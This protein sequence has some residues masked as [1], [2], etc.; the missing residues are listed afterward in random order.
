MIHIQKLVKFKLLDRVPGGYKVHD[1]LDVND[2]KE[3]AQAR[4]A[5]LAEV[6]A[7]AG[8]KGGVKRQANRVANA[9]QVASKQSSPLHSVP[10]KKDR[11]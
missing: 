9:K 6:R 11:G 2:T 5:Y 3:E 8:R 4:A 1:Y 7:Q 10:R